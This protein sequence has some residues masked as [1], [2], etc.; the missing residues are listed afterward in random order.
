MGEP[1]GHN[2]S[3]PWQIWRFQWLWFGGMIIGAA[4]DLAVSVVGD[5]VEAW[6]DI[7]FFATAAALLHHAVRRRSN[8]ARLLVVPFVVLS[9]VEILSH[10]GF[11]ASKSGT[12]WLAI[13]QVGS[14]GA[15]GCL[16]FTPAARRW[17]ART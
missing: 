15:A 13:L 2:D 14:M 8:F 4:Y 10:D 16:L 12:V 9:F 6:I 5:Y 17:F 1:S 3:P 11:E 7:L